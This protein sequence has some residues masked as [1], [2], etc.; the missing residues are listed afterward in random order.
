MCKHFSHVFDGHLQSEGCNTLTKV[1]QSLTN[2]LWL[3]LVALNRTPIFINFW[4]P[5][6]GVVWH[7]Q[8]IRRK[9][10]CY[11]FATTHVQRVLN[12]GLNPVI[13]CNG[14][15]FLNVMDSICSQGKYALIEEAIQIQKHPTI[16]MNQRGESLSLSTLWTQ[17]V[18]N[19]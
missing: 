8:T 11:W 5:D 14:G 3:R 19:Q 2:E 10:N 16:V 15:M 9:A 1:S 7:H 17:V 12:E 13:H 18:V 4:S 6:E